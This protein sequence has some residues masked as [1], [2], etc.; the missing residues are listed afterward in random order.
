MSNDITLIESKDL[1][2]M[3]QESST[4]YT[5]VEIGDELAARIEGDTQS[6]FYGGIHPTHPH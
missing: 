5:A 2:A 6:E 4:E 1:V 3:L